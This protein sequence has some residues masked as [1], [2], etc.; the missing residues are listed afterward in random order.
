MMP[1]VTAMCPTYGR[2]HLLE[3][4]IES[5]LRQDYCGPKELLVLNDLPEQTLHCDE[6]EVRVI[7]MPKRCE[8]LGQKRNQ[9]A[10]HSQGELIMTWSDDDIHLSNRIS[11]N[12]KQWQ[13]GHYVTEGSH[14][15]LCK[16][17]KELKKSRLCGPFL[18][19]RNEFW[20][21][22][23]IPDA[24]TG[25]DLQFLQKASQTLRVVESKETS[26]IYRW[27]VTERFHASW[28]NARQSAWSD[29]Q[30]RVDETLQ[31]GQE[32]KGNILL[33][34]RWRQDYEKLAQ[35]LLVA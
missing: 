7:N 9:A 16:T 23:G 18:M 22:G 12:V 29:I 26:Y 30:Q 21:L 10:R 34:P 25:E 27:G 11:S 33:K 6:P 31:K 15:F 2:V 24:F 8:N 28:F 17:Q 3:E 5:F 19:E 4:A 13:K 14:I 35:D 1:F 32:P 20:K